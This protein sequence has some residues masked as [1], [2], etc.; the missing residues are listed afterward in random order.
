M[1]KRT[2]WAL[3]A[4]MQDDGVK[5][6]NRGVLIEEKLLHFLQIVTDGVGMRRVA[7][8]FHR[9]TRTV[10]RSFIEMIDTLYGYA[11]ETFSMEGRWVQHPRVSCTEEFS[12]FS[13]CIGAIDG[14]HIPLFVEDDGQARW[15]NRKAVNSTNVLAV[16]DFSGRFRY[17]LVGWEGSAHDA[18]VLADAVRRG[19]KVPEGR[20][21]L[22]DAAYPLANGVLTPYRTVQ[23]HLQRWRLQR[24]NPSTPQELFNYRHSSLRM[25]VER[26]FGQLKQ[27]FSILT[28]MR[29]YPLDVQL[30]LIYALF[31]LWN[32]I[33]ESEGVDLEKEV[34]DVGLRL[35]HRSFNE[36]DDE[37]T[38]QGMDRVRDLLTND[39]WEDYDP[40]TGR[41]RDT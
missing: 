41:A 28:R 17:V 14:T 27:R 13:E 33:V 23:Y 25:V 9:S 32:I 11:K 40:M 18:W 22:G 4:R 2:F 21:I 1:S 24:R 3:C 31:G 5:A 30:R 37:G 10:H 12:V 35:W 16:V 29:Q 15:R 6:T 39:L 8:D 7:F 34:S 19:F 26:A 36:E 20:Y 38:G